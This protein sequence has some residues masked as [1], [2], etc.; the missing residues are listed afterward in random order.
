MIPKTEIISTKV[1]GTVFY[2]GVRHTFDLDSQYTN[3]NRI[4]FHYSIFPNKLGN[5]DILCTMYIKVIRTMLKQW[6]NVSMA[7]LHLYK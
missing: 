6:L 7:T 5:L 2:E 1:N 4:E 3:F